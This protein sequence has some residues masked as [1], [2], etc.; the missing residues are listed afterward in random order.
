MANSSK[1]FT[2][3]LS[4]PLVIIPATMLLV[5]EFA[6]RAPAVQRALPQPQLYYDV[7]VLPRLERMNA[8]LQS[9]TL[10]V[11]FV[12]S[13]IVRTN[14]RPLVFDSVV[15]SRGARKVVSFNGGF[16]GMLT[17][18]SR[19]YLE[20]FWLPHVRPSYVAL[21]VRF[22][23][24]SSER[25]AEDW[26]EFKS[27]RIERQWI[28]DSYMARLNASLLSKVKLLNY[29]GAFSAWFSD[30]WSGIRE[31]D[32]PVDQRGYGPTELTLTQALETG[33]LR[34]SGTYS[35]G[36]A[37]SN[38]EVGM[39]A[40]KR[41]TAAARQRGIQFIIANIPEYCGRYLNAPDGLARYQTYLGILRQ[42]AAEEQVTLID[43]TDGDPSTWC[44]KDLFSDFHHMSPAGAR[45]LSI[46]LGEAIGAMM[47]PSATR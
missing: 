29:Q 7:G 33:K 11:L 19:L 26:E 3:R 9:D 14:I 2:L 47:A 35:G 25:R 42:V 44:D 8:L 28:S 15:S 43:V 39:S 6:F 38:F 13:S 30:G 12:G 34:G 22:G 17:D 45:R 20:N 5:A 10:D 27:S 41:S 31:V 16:S 1:Q 21:G 36:F 46:E 32:F 40:L 18:P 37:P 23:E 4:S 24:L